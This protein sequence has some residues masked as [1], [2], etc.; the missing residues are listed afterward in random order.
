MPATPTLSGLP[1]ARTQSCVMS[2]KGPEGSDMSR[3]ALLG[4]AVPALAGVVLTKVR[5]E[6]MEMMMIRAEAAM[7]MTL[8][9]RRGGGGGYFSVMMRMPMIRMVAVTASHTR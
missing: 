3:R 4:L 1:S 2:A 6:V 5:A 8:T 9:R 7:M